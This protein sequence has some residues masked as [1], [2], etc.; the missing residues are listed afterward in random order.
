MNQRPLVG[1]E[2]VLGTEHRDTLAS[3]GNLGLTL[4]SQGKCEEASEKH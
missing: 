1:S 4:N 2:K 3:V